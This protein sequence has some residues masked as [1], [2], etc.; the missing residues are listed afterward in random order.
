MAESI[1]I[2]IAAFMTLCIYSFLY[3]DN[4]FYKFAEH[5]FV[6]VSAGYFIIYYYHQSVK[7]NLL[8]HVSAVWREGASPWNLL[9]IIPGILGFF[10]ILRFVPKTSW[11][12]RWSIAFYVGA[13]SGIS[14]PRMMKARIITQIQGTMRP[15][16]SAELW[17]RLTADFT[18]EN[19]L[20][21]IGTPIMIIG[22]LCSLAYFFFSKPHRGALGG[23][24]KVGITFLMIGFGASFGYT[25]MARISL[26]IGRTQFM[27]DE[28]RASLVALAFIVVGL[29]LWSVLLKK[30]DREAVT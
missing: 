29:V 17:N 28:P 3:R 19:F 30:E 20:A 1:W 7:P 21:F 27:I 26:L 11:L 16:F 4:P 18:L 25:V 12:S 10:F 5:L 9:A 2:F 14:I 23:A 6:G 13:G 24:A 15:F 8:D 22:V